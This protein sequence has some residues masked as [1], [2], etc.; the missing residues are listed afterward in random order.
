M[1]GV[2]SGY[3]GPGHPGQHA[4]S[5]PSIITAVEWSLYLASWDIIIRGIGCTV[6]DSLDQK[7]NRQVARTR[8][9]PIAR[10]AVSTK[11]ANVFTLEQLAAAAVCF[12]HYHMLLYPMRSQMVFLG[13]AFSAP[14]YLMCRA[15]LGHYPLQLERI[16]IVSSV[17]WDTLKS[18]PDFLTITFLSISG[19][20]WTVIF[21]TVYV[22]QDYED[23]LKA[24]APGLAVRLGLKGTKP[25]LSL[26]SAVQIGGLVL[27]GKHAGFG[28]VHFALSC[29]GTAISLSAMML[30][31]NLENPKSCAWWFEWG[32]YPIGGSMVLG[33]LREYLIKRSSLY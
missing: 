1:K 3:S 2:L 7:F 32:N 21:D 24:G 5:I 11:Q 18:S 19:T 9:R 27:A 4:E 12:H 23:D 10:G 31:V 6:N 28:P 33:L 8:N 30:K 16:A 26:L 17:S 25:A 29:G 15:I 20:L 22:H 14:L 13:F